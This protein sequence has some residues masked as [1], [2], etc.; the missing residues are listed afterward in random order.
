M[1]K[2]TWATSKNQYKIHRKKVSKEYELCEE[3]KAKIPIGYYCSSDGGS[4]IWL[5]KEDDEIL[6]AQI[7]RPLSIWLC[8]SC[9]DK[10]KDRREEIRHIH[11]A[12]NY[13]IE[14]EYF[15]RYMQFIKWYI[16][17]IRE[18]KG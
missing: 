4:S 1:T 3:C 17:D 15:K 14:F 10:N 11:L 18:H 13:K 16:E 12:Y 6:D 5:I 7:I 9:Y 8:N 2:T